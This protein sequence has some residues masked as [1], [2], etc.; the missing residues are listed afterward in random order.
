MLDADGTPWK[1]PFTV[2]PITWSM[3]L[4]W[5]LDRTRFPS[6]ITDAN[7]RLL[8]AFV[9]GNVCDKREGSF[10]FLSFVRQRTMS[11]W[12]HGYE[13]CLGVGCWLYF[14]RSILYSPINNY[15]LWRAG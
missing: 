10:K 5:T 7:D 12:E 8:Q 13:A 3:M 2:I 1:I 6:N 9:N 4:P 14:I 11:V 15:L